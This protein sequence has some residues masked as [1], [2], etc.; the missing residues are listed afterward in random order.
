MCNSVY[1]ILNVY[2]QVEEKQ[3][4]LSKKEEVINMDIPW[5]YFDGAS[6]GN[7]L[8]GGLG[9]ILYL[10]SNHTHSFQRWHWVGN[11]QLL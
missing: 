7:P 1:N 9:G 8:V 11:K 5:A 3:K 2:P 10:S 4:I 6:Q